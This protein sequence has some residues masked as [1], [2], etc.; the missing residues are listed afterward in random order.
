MYSEGKK[1]P[2]EI[3]RNALTYAK[4]NNYNYI[5]ID[6]AGRLHIDT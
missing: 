5:L 1:D 2:V 6:T 4:E 3:V